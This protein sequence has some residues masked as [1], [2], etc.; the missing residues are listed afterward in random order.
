MFPLPDLSQ[1]FQSFDTF[2]NLLY[3]IVLYCNRSFTAR[4]VV[5]TIKNLMSFSDEALVKTK[6][7]KL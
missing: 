2:I 5:R 7:K 1:V 4:R 6:V 3:C